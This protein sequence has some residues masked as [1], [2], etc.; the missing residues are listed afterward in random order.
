MDRGATSRRI[1]GKGNPPP[2]NLGRRRAEGSRKMTFS[3]TTL[4][5]NT[6]EELVGR[7]RG[8]RYLYTRPVEDQL[9]SPTQK[10]HLDPHIV[11][12]TDLCDRLHVPGGVDEVPHPRQL[13]TG[14]N[15]Q[16]YPKISHKFGRATRGVTCTPDGKIKTD[17]SACAGRSRARDDGKT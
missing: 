16:E 3:T 2:R 4:N 5:P 6:P 1:E 14:S 13:P 8:R 10:T 9:N 12:K 11:E 7:I 15:V 17:E